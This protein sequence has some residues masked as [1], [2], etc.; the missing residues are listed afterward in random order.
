MLAPTS[1]AA[2]S[3]RRLSRTESRAHTRSLLLDAAAAVFARDGYGG[4]SVSVIAET[5]GFSVGALYSNFASKED[6]FLALFDEHLAGHLRDL[7]RIA[8]DEP[9]GG[10]RNAAFGR[11]LTEVAD[12]HGDWG[13]LELEFLR[14]ALRRPDLLERLAERWARPRRAI[15]RLIEADHQRTSGSPGDSDTMPDTEAVATV[16]LAL[17]DGLITQRRIKPDTVPESLFAEALGWLAAGLA[18]QTQR[19]KDAGEIT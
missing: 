6:L 16:I 18:T 8:A 15:A 3:R 9:P 2:G 13:A 19:K 1:R 11:Y 5:A 4:A 12:G 14:Y 17:F 7:D 10:G